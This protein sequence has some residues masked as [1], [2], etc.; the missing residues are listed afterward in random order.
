M[1]K[2]KARPARL[3]NLMTCHLMTHQ[4]RSLCRTRVPQ[5]NQMMIPI[6]FHLNVCVIPHIARP[7]S[8]KRAQ[9]VSCHTATSRT[10]PLT[11]MRPAYGHLTSIVAISM[12]VSSNVQ[13]LPSLIAVL[14]RYSRLFL[15]SIGLPRHSMTISV[16]GMP[17]RTMRFTNNL[18]SMA[19]ITKGHGLPLWP[20]LSD[21]SILD[22][23]LTTCT[24]LS[25]WLVRIHHSSTTF[26]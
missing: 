11:L 6:M 13:L 2:A 21:P 16:S 1:I 18:Y 19:I 10:V 8:N 12:R 20:R 25:H 5:M 15:E 26:S 23:H 4:L 7:L 24:F 9:G 22:Q 3:S 17:R 14:P